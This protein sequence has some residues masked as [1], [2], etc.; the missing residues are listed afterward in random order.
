MQEI[1]VNITEDRDMFFLFVAIVGGGGIALIVAVTGIIFGTR[2]SI[3]ENR[4]REMSR[5]EIAAYVA[6]G[7]MSSE[8]GERLMNAGNKPSST[9]LA[10][11]RDAKCC[12]S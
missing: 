7:S 4:E 5:R 3:R 11:K 8:A 6:E 1:L 2:K 12:T 9:E 10:M